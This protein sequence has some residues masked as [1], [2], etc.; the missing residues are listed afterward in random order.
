MTAVNTQHNGPNTA[1]FLTVCQWFFL[2]QAKPN[3]YVPSLL[4]HQTPIS[5]HKHDYLDPLAVY[6]EYLS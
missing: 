2:F 1:P 6:K 5:F 4:A 3:E